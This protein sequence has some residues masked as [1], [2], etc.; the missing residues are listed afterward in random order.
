M[1]QYCD[2]CD[3][4]FWGNPR[5]IGG[6]CERCDCNGNIDFNVNFS[7]KITHL[8][9]SQIP[10]SCDAA[11]GECLKCLHNTGGD[12][13]EHCL[14]GFFGDAQV[15]SCQRC[16]CNQLGTNQE[17]GPCD[18][19]TGQCPCHPNVQGLQCDQCAPLHYDLASGKGCFGN[20]GLIA[21]F[22]VVPPA[23]ATRME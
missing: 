10:E 20:L 12:Q 6:S 8:S 11:T 14:D 3:V 15:R 22:K 19:I 21:L 23:I 2:N 1:G 17:A 16:V 7:H 18:R 5:E 9:I 4:N 13:C